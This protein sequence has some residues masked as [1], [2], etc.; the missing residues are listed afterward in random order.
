MAE[1]VKLLLPPPLVKENCRQAQYALVLCFSGGA[2]TY[3]GYRYF[4]IKIKVGIVLG[5]G[6]KV[7]P[8]SALV[9]RHEMLRV[10]Q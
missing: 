6:C 5:I 9:K 1:L 4:Q 2:P 3:L 10:I 7:T 8:I